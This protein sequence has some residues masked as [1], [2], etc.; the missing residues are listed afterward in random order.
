MRRVIFSFI[1]NVISIVIITALLVTVRTEGEALQKEAPGL[2]TQGI[3]ATFHLPPETPTI[4]DD[5]LTLN[6][7]IKT[8]PYRLE[9][10]PKVEKIEFQSPVSVSNNDCPIMYEDNFD[11]EPGIDIIASTY[12][13]TIRFMRREKVGDKYKITQYSWY[14]N[15][16]DPGGSGHMVIADFNNDGLKDLL[17]FRNNEG[18]GSNGHWIGYYKRTGETSFDITVIKNRYQRNC[19]SR[20]RNY[21]TAT[22]MSAGDYNGD[23]YKDVF[24]ISSDGRVYVA[25]NNKGNGF[26]CP[27][28]LFDTRLRTKRSGSPVIATGDMDNDG[29]LDIV[30]GSTDY[31]DIRIY[32]NEN[33][34]F[35][36]VDLYKTKGS[37]ILSTSLIDKDSDPFVGA[38]TGIKLSDINNDGLLDIVISTD[39]W[40]FKPRNVN[41]RRL[42]PAKNPSKVGGR[43][44]VIYQEREGDKVIFRT[45]YIGQEGYDADGLWVGDID[46]NGTV[47]IIVP[48]G[49]H[50]RSFG[51]FINQ[52]STYYVAYGTLTTLPLIT[53]NPGSGSA[54]WNNFDSSL[55]RITQVKLNVDY[56]PQDY[57]IRFKIAY[58]N[59]SGQWNWIDVTDAVNSDQW[60]SV[61][62]I[63]L[64][65]RI[66]FNRSS[67]ESPSTPIINKVEVLYKVVPNKLKVHSWKEVR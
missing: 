28:F 54:D 63:Q 42:R 3:P 4:F 18:R 23:G 36:R 51:V 41:Y 62:G 52:A 7:V 65:W 35:D 22:F 20:V 1:F 43:L 46:G 48:D 29:D 19:W 40:Q 59:S 17:V 37:K 57:D 32:Y 9:L 61:D 60:I 67:G 12:G 56:D 34:N 5:K 24:L 6:V 39:N 27:E 13:N 44:Y 45:D 49:N 64:L 14:S 10:K 47:D 8:D 30:V 16:L 25:L 21:W 55:Y 38:A 26:Q 53:H 50:T 2:F 31:G 33:G 58:N 11:G 15:S 66:E